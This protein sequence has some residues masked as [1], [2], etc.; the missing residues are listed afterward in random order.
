MNRTVCLFLIFVSALKVSAQDTYQQRVVNYISTYKDLAIEEMKR[1]GVPASITIGQ[2]IIE[3]EAGRSSLATLANNH[4]GIKCHE[5]WKGDTY[6]FDDDAPNECF[7][8]YDSPD[9][10]FKDHSNF[11]KNKPRYACLFQMDIT[12]YKGWSKGLK[13]CGYATNPKYAEILITAIENNSLMQYDLMGLDPN[14]IAGKNQID[15]TD[16][17]CKIQNQDPETDA[18]VSDLVSDPQHGRVYFFNNIKCIELKQ[19]ETLQKI[20][21]EYELGM[22]RILKYNDMTSKTKVQPGDRIYLQLKHRNGDVA[23]HTVKEDETMFEISQM[24]GIQLAYLYEKNKMIFGT[25]PE[26]GEILNLRSDRISP[27]KLRSKQKTIQKELT[28]YH[29][30]SL[31]ENIYVV[32]KGDTLYAISKMYDLTVAELKQLNNLTSDVLSIGDKLKVK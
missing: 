17:Q 30:D 16:A 18:I 23:Y 20:A 26:S 4:F 6:H 31:V 22:K 5:D 21:V 9:Q 24:H 14:Y 15:S 13:A 8:K 12:D 32:K 29:P 11:L 1:T 3:T 27:P 28:S 19:G 25:Q 7:R 2:G 10:S